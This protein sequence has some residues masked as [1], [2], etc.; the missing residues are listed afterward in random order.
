[1]CLG[2]G[3]TIVRA[4]VCLS[5]AGNAS[6]STLIDVQLENGMR[7]A[8][9]PVNVRKNKQALINYVLRRYEKLRDQ[10][11]AARDQYWDKARY[12]QDKIID[13]KETHGQSQAPGADP[14]A[15]ADP[16]DIG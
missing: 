13:F 3:E 5:V 7:V 12:Y 9:T 10:A 16:A 11:T 14:T 15:Y 2:D 6:V 1:V 4:E 8:L